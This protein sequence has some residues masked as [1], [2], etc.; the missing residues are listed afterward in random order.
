MVIG[1]RN[2]DAVL[3]NLSKK[4][5]SADLY[6]CGLL[7]SKVAPWLAASPDGILAIRTSTGDLKLAVVEVKTRVSPEKVAE[8]DRIAKKYKEPVIVCDYGDDIWNECIEEDHS[9]QL[10]VQM[11]VTGINYC[12]YIVSRAGTAGSKGRSIYMVSGRV[13]NRQ[14]NEQYEILA[15]KIDHLLKPFFTSNNIDEVIA[16]M[17]RGLDANQLEVIRTR[18]PFFH[19]IRLDAISCNM[20]GFPS[21]ALFKS[22]FQSLYNIIKGGLDANT[23]QY[24]SIRPNVKV[25]FEQ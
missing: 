5:Y 21:C 4:Q 10:L 22:S 23:Q 2:E 16:K 19:R 13:T 18:W 9:N 11:M 15:E 25:S 24:V 14:L 3:L 12:H 8:A 20:A 7:E 17:P 6:E 1:S